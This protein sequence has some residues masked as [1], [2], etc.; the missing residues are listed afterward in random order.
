[1]QLQDGLWVE[2]LL[3][4]DVPSPEK[5]PRG[6]CR[7]TVMLGLTEFPEPEWVIHSVQVTPI[8]VI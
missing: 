5:T 3:W 2:A 8:T 6:L 7:M 4:E 1:M